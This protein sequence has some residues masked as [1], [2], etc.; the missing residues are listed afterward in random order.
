M[1]FLNLLKED[2]QLKVTTHTIHLELLMF[3]FVGH[4]QKFGQAMILWL[5]IMQLITNFNN[6]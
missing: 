2:S 1:P 6:F 4:G 5:Y 3:L